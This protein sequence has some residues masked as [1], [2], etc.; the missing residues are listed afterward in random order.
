MDHFHINWYE[1]QKEKS[2]L[3]RKAHEVTIINQG[4]R[5]LLIKL[6]FKLEN[7]DK[8][9]D[10]EFRLRNEYNVVQSTLWDLKWRNN[11][12][13]EKVALAQGLLLNHILKTENKKEFSYIE[14]QLEMFM[15]RVG[16]IDTNTQIRYNQL[17]EQ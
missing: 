9:E 10:F 16:N 13:S 2:E 14:N 17:K 15:R 1:K 4:L 6:N 12:E 3:L 11:F 7:K 8:Y 5:E